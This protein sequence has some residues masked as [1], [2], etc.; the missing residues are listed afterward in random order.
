MNY[1]KKLYET[2]LANQSQVGIEKT[3]NKDTFVLVPAFHG[4]KE[5]DLQVNISSTGDFLYADIAKKSIIFPAT[6]ESLGRTGTNAPPHALHDTLTYVAGDFGRYL[7][8]VNANKIK[9]KH[10]DYL[11]NLF[12]WST[13]THGHAKL[14]AIYAYLSKGT[15][16]KDLI[17]EGVLT[18]D[19][20]GILQSKQEYLKKDLS[21][22]FVRFHVSVDSESAT[23]NDY[24]PLWENRHFYSLYEAHA[25]S[26]QT[27]L[28]GLCTVSGKM[29]QLMKNH[30]KTINLHA[31]NAKLI[32]S[33]SN[34]LIQN[35]GLFPR[36]TDENKEEQA[37]G[38]S[39]EVSMKA[40]NALS[41][42]IRK[43]GIK[44]GDGK[45][46]L[47]IWKTKDIEVYNPLLGI[48]EIVDE[49]IIEP[50]TYE[51]Y[52]SRL[53]DALK[54][55]LIA[56]TNE[57]E[58]INF[59]LLN[60]VVDGRMHVLNYGEYTEREYF[61]HID[62]WNH[63]CVWKLKGRSGVYYNGA[64]SAYDIAWAIL[65]EKDLATLNEKKLSVIYEDVFHYIF[66]GKNI[67]KHYIQQVFRNLVNFEKNKDENEWE[68]RLLIGCAL[69]NRF[70]EKENYSM[71]LNPT[72]TNRDYLFGRLLA[73]ADKVEKDAYKNTTARTTNA[74]K[75][76][77]NYQRKPI[78]T[79][80][81]LYLRLIPYLEKSAYKERY[82]KL[83]DEVMNL[84]QEN[85]FNNNSLTPVFL[86]GFSNQR[87]DFYKKKKQVLLPKKYRLKK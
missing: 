47:L 21:K 38:V 3:K 6:E 18:L 25:L 33:G 60:S 8:Q 80:N 12:K 40:H 43:Q 10:T 78:D 24:I 64:P 77:S 57:S 56:N 45:Q 37:A 62:R 44:P 87:N 11:D 13:G 35:D 39:I 76:M 5:S 66:D 31:A 70:Y 75:Y 73:I 34:F 63:A 28:K 55:R 86:L 50:D 81:T 48:E 14:Q 1:L 20:T 79:W 49:E 53:L 82:G 19:E 72:N 36:Y 42:L 61:E 71:T 23:D 84:F 7:N 83:V 69:F 74:M 15:L 4:Y 65:K 30:P 59:L 17:A 26:Q 9:N 16:T 67:H 54:G 68:K 29:T 52:A 58:T 22:I 2:Y 46:V 32:S 85:E 51:V 41:W 27:G